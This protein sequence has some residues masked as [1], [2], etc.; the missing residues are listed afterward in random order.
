MSGSFAFPAPAADAATSALG[1]GAG[2]WTSSTVP[3]PPDADANNK[4]LTGI[5][6]SSTT[7]CA[8]VGNYFSLDL[9]A[10]PPAVLNLSGTTCAAQQEPTPARLVSDQRDH[11]ALA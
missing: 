7:Q 9:S 6:C 2:V 11:G 1:P 8:A 5:S 4:D 3:M 10:T